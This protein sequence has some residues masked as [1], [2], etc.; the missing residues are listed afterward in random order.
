MQ[1]EES[2]DA[3]EGYCTITGVGVGVDFGTESNRKT[4]K[5]KHKET[6]EGIGTGAGIC[7]LVGI[8][9]GKGKVR[10]VVTHYYWMLVKVRRQDQMNIPTQLRDTVSES[11][12]LMHPG[13][14]KMLD[15]A[16]GIWFSHIHRR[17]IAM[18]SKSK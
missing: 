8:G 4:S 5:E 15:I 7:A 13:T 1:A 6:G 16:E 9:I 17:I 10:I 14:D 18:G 11:I 3:R 12:H 2:D